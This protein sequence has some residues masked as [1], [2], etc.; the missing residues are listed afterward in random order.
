MRQ[1]I[2]IKEAIATNGDL[3]GGGNEVTHPLAHAGKICWPFRV[4]FTPSYPMFLRLSCYMETCPS[5]DHHKGI[6]C[7]FGKK[8]LLHLF[9]WVD[10]FWML[11]E[12]TVKHLQW[13]EWGKHLEKFQMSSL[14]V[15]KST[16]INASVRAC[17]LFKL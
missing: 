15:Y 16:F 5:S 9:H 1:I 12:I 17:I 3:N 10:V 14:W 11:V 13:S 8:V 7:T 4:H 2:A 6:W